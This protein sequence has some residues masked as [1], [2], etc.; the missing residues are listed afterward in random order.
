[1]FFVCCSRQTLRFF[2]IIPIIVI[3]FALCFNI[4]FSASLSHS[5]L[6]TDM[7]YTVVID[8]YGRPTRSVEGPD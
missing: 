8:I 7:Y 3:M 6:V 2:C 5:E 4:I 1:M